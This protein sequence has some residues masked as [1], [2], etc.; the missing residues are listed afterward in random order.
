[1]A[2]DLKDAGLLKIQDGELKNEKFWFAGAL[3]VWVNAAALCGW[4]FL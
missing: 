3:W 1:M 4:M 2:T